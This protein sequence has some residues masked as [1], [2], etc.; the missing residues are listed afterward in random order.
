MLTSQF[1]RASLLFSFLFCFLPMASQGRSHVFFCYINRNALVECRSFKKSALSRNLGISL[2]IVR[3][4][5]CATRSVGCF[6]GCS[7]HKNCRGTATDDCLKSLVPD[8]SGWWM[9]W[10]RGWIRT[11]VDLVCLDPCCSI[12]SDIWGPLM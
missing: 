4:K 2:V 11:V 3:V 6:G 9:L 1:N 5:W 8:R 12:A 10:Y 7:V